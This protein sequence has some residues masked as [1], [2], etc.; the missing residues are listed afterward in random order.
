M[1]QV[2]VGL[3]A[4]PSEDQISGRCAECT[5]HKHSNSRKRVSGS[6]ATDLTIVDLPYGP[7][8]AGHRTAVGIVLI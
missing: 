2:E 6:L 5:R 4:L 7:T 3:S 8:I 1:V